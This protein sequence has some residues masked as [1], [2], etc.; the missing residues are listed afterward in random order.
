M[1]VT[2]SIDKT[3]TAR[4]QRP[5]KLF[6][7]PASRDGG[8]S[9]ATEK[10]RWLLEILLGVVGAAVVGF[11]GWRGL[12]VHTTDVR[13]GKIEVRLG[14]IQT[15]LS[16]VN[17]KID[18]L[19]DT[20]FDLI[21]ILHPRENVIVLEAERKYRRLLSASSLLATPLAPAPN[22]QVVYAR[23][24]HVV[25]GMLA[26][27]LPP[28]HLGKSIPVQAMDR[29]KVLSISV[30]RE[31]FKAVEIAQESGYRHRYEH[32]KDVT[33]GLTLGATVAR[34]EVIGH[35]IPTPEACV[36]IGVIDP[37]GRFV[38]PRPFLPPMRE[39]SP[40]EEPEHKKPKPH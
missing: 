34:E 20:L 11:F 22:P 25:P 39:Q 1:R 6:E 31:G 18:R 19:A 38:D 13:L 3:D 26:V 23:P 29:G 24:S 30:D 8:G 36:R 33:P 12:T 2:T 10:K 5:E 37:D 27:T 4:V 40:P 15:G 14:T 7:Q 16:T 21:A 9:M 28:E 17:N 32:L 35:A